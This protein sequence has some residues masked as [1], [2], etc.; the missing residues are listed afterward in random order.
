[1]FL[2]SSSWWNYCLK[3]FSDWDMAQWVVY[4]PTCTRLWVQY[5]TLQKKKK[6]AIHLETKRELYF[7]YI[8]NSAFG[9]YRLP[10]LS[11]RCRTYCFQSSQTIKDT[12]YSKKQKNFLRAGGVAK[13]VKHLPST[14]A[15]HWVQNPILKNTSKYFSYVLICLIFLWVVTSSINLASDVFQWQI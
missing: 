10:D 9:C 11:T 12:E 1:M 14:S 6:K 4:F 15:R 13:A 5:P 7:A 3:T 2:F 8:N